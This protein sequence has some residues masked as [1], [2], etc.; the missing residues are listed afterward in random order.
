VGRASRFLFDNAI[1]DADGTLIETTG[2]CKEGMDIAYNGVW[3][4]HTLVVSLA[5]TGEVLSIVNRSGN[6][7]SH[8]HAAWELDRALFLCLRAGFRK[9]LMRGD[10]DFSQDE[11]LDGWNAMSRVRFTFGYNV[12]PN[13]EEF[14]ANLPESAWRKLERPAR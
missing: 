9:V 12:M 2:Q 8:E 11:H 10:T 3:G 7:P 1:L 6:R 4:Y 5:N 13:L 14:G